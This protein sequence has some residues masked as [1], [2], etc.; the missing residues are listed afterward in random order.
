M[1]VKDHMTKNPITIKA[2]TSVS[3]ALD[4]MNQNDF[5]RL[6]V[7]DDENHL[8]GL[9][10]EGIVTEGSGKNVT[11]LSIYELNYLLSKTRTE[12]LMVKDVKTIGPD[13]FL[14][15]AAAEMLKNGISVLPVVNED[16]QVIGI[17]TEKDI[18]QTFVDLMGYRTQGTRFIIKCEDVPGIFAKAA[19]LFANENANLE[20][21]AV[22]HTDERDTEIVIKA[23]GEISV[24]KMTQILEDN[25]F[26]ITRIIQTDAEGNRTFH[27]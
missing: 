5:H 9:I 12:E 14:E 19:T 1:Y 4:L 11:S 27:R 24:E 6:P 16:N 7:V 15:D 23:T 8:I 25:G 18:F 22:Y 13:E 21:L 3:K 20:N 17:I 10:T 26:D 2:D